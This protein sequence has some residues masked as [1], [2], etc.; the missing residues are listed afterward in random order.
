MPRYNPTINHPEPASAVRDCW[1]TLYGDDALD[2]PTRL[3]I[4]ASEDFSYYLQEIPG[5]FA[6]I[7]ADDGIGHA[8]P[9][10]SPHYD[11]ND[12]LLEP[13][14]RLYAQLVGAPLP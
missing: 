3:P 5:A 7:G 9:C 10:H 2:T 8:D 1:R 11:F 13:V 6:L 14:V 12:R 4:M